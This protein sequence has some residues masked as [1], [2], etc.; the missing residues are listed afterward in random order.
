MTRTGAKSSD[1]GAAV[2]RRVML[3]G[4]TVT[5]VAMPLLAACGGGDDSTAGSGGQATDG[6]A[7]D[8][9]GSGDS[10]GGGGLKVPESEVPVGGGVI[11]KSDQVVVTQ[12]SKGDFK[13]FTAICTH[14]GCTVGSVEDGKIICP[15]HGSQFSIEDGSPQAGPASSPLASKQVSVAGGEVTVSA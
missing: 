7:T 5:G 15:C 9:G 6:G 12:P 8:S 4:A 3:R 2:T 11:L 13:A 10:G 14:Q 1:E